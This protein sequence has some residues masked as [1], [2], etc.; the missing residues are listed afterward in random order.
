M[1]LKVEVFVSSS[2][3]YCPQAEQVVDEAKREIGDEMDV[4]VINIRNDREKALDYGLMAVP[5]IAINGVV[6]FLG[7][8][9]KDELMA[10]LK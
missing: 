9:T 4:E 1:V 7:A 10:K 5:A 8:P 3:P 2:C 6:E